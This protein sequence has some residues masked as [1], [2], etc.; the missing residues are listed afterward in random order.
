[1]QSS[2]R[3]TTSLR[4]RERQLVSPKT[5]LDHLDALGIPDF[6]RLLEQHA[7]EGLTAIE[8]EILQINIGRLCNMACRHCHVDAGPDRKTEN[9]APE[10]VEAC[11]RALDHLP[12]VH[13]VDITGGAPELHPAFR[14]LVER[15]SARGLQGSDRCN[16]TVLLLP[17][18]VD[19]PNFLAIQGVEVVCSLPHYRQNHTDSQRGEGAFAQSIKAL[20]RL[21]EVGYGQGNPRQRLTLMSNPAGAF[22]PARQPTLEAQWKA[23][24]ERE[25]EVQFDR[26]IGLNNMPI[27]RFLEWLV[28]TDNLYSYMARLQ[29]AFNPRAVESLMCRNTLSVGWDGRLFD[30]DFNQM[31]DMDLELENSSRPTIHDVVEGLLSGRP[32]RTDRHCFGC[33]AGSGSSC[34]GSTA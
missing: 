25:H 20:R 26:L 24:L 1:M 9:M 11:I 22:L 7:L 17:R 13:T 31:L 10:T 15:C 8:P 33:T 12:S 14:D 4:T 27:A 34:G 28:Q 18:M 21:N 30:C 29:R 32:I 2:P 6:D 16:L 19:L 5:Q 23:V 3:A